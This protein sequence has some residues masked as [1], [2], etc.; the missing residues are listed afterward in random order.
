MH[1]EEEAALR[2]FNAPTRASS[3]TDR[4]TR[5]SRCVACSLTLHFHEHGDLPQR[6]PYDAEPHG[7]GRSFYAQETCLLDRIGEQRCGHVETAWTHEPLDEIPQLALVFLRK[8]EGTGDG[9]RVLLERLSQVHEP[10]VLG[11]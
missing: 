4:A 5:P 1:D 6:T 2:H 9:A 10:A 3:R 7:I 8:I 11:Q